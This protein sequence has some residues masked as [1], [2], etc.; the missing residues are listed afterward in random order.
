MQNDYTSKKFRKWLDKLQRES[1]Q[2]E[3]LVSGFVILGLFSSIDPLIAKVDSIVNSVDRRTGGLVAGAGFVLLSINYIL[4][5]NLVVHLVLRGLWI[6]AIG[7]RYYSGDIIFEEL[8]YSKKFTKYLSKKI[9]SFDKYI[10]KLED[11]CS[12]IF[13]LS[14]L[15]V[16]IGLSFLIYFAIIF[17]L[18]VVS[19]SN[20]DSI[21]IVMLVG[22]A[23]IGFAIVLL[24]ML[25]DFLG[26][27]ILKKNETIAMLYFPIYWIMSYVSLSFIY[28]PILYNFLDDRKGKRILFWM[29]PFYITIATLTTLRYEQSNFHRSQNAA[30]ENFASR[31]MYLEGVEDSRKR[32]FRDFAIQRKNVSKNSLRVF[33]THNASLEDIILKLN[34]SLSLENDQR[35]VN[36]FFSKLFK[37]DVDYDSNN[38]KEYLKTLNSITVIKID[39]ITYSDNFIASFLENGQ[40]GY[41]TFLD[42]KNLERGRHTFQIISKTTNRNDSIVND[43]LGTIPFWYYPTK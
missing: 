29:I 28:R 38:F 5:F 4:I 15:I 37:D 22:F 30:S 9:V 13:S 31:G 21:V 39:S 18:A 25:V 6:G 32:Y 3:L 27:G 24:I 40:R 19:A 20:L 41:E 7:L 17:A 23:V 34:D 16:F 14:F 11:Y 42:L 8:N 26:Q 2:L 33:L 12:I 1:W 36:T 43:T 35:G 10:G